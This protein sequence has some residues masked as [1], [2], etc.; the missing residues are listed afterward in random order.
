[1]SD[2]YKEAL[3][4]L[5]SCFFIKGHAILAYE[6]II[7][8]Q[9]HYIK[10]KQEIAFKINNFSN[11]LLLALRMFETEAMDGLIKDLFGFLAE[12][13]YMPLSE[14]TAIFGRL[15]YDISYADSKVGSL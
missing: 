11:R 10:N 5:D 4:A 2:S 15:I 1:L 9:T 14:L 12:T 8:L 6:N 7:K 13:G 3:K